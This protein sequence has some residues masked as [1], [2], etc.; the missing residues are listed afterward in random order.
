V[1]VARTARSP[2][3][4]LETDARRSEILRAALEAFAEQSPDTVPMA[5]LARRAGSS[6]ALIYHY[7]GDRDGLA[8]AALGLAADELIAAMQVDPTASV[9][10]QL[11]TGLGI[12]LDYLAAHPASWA[13]LLRAS[14]GSDE[15]IAAIARRV[16]D[17]A[18]ALSIRAVTGS[19]DGPPLLELAIRG[20]LEMVKASCLHWLATGSPARPVLHAL[21]SGTFAGCVEAAQ[22]ADPGAPYDRMSP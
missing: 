11:D 9:G 5:E 7:F 17:H 18:T 15:R 21:L 19:V 8:A 10:E 16:D 6:P 14:A 3:R 1:E 4:R 2:R 22:T 12:Y 20:W 13:A